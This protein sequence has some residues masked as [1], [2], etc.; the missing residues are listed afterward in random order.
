MSLHCDAGTRKPTKK[1]EL[2][3]HNRKLRKQ[4]NNEVHLRE[5]AAAGSFFVRPS[6]P[7]LRVLLLRRRPTSDPRRVAI[8]FQEIGVEKDSGSRLSFS[9]TFTTSHRSR[10][11]PLAG[12]SPK[13]ISVESIRQ[14]KRTRF[15]RWAR[16]RPFVR[17]SV[18]LFLL[19]A[20]PVYAQSTGSDPWDNRCQRPQSCLHRHHCDRVVAGCHRG[21]RTDVRLRRRP[22]Q[23]ERYFL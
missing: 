17:Y 5:P 10:E 18:P 22:V 21:R 8:S 13:E 6:F 20:L 2:H 23:K 7:P 16:S 19:S 3:P 14:P 15:F 9:P 12:K 1:S 11:L 4:P